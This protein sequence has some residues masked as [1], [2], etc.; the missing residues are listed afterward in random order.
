MVAWST[1][2]KFQPSVSAISENDLSVGGDIGIM[3]LKV[4]ILGEG[5]QIFLVKWGM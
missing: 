5:N 1:S 2:Q 4:G 3:N